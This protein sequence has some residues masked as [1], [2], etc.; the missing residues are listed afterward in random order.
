MIISISHTKLIGPWTTSLTWPVAYFHVIT[1]NP[2]PGPTLILVWTTFYTTHITYC[3]LSVWHNIAPLL[4][5]R[6]YIKELSNTHLCKMLNDPYF[7]GFA[8][9]QEIFPCKILIPSSGSVQRKFYLWSQGVTKLESI[10]WGYVYITLTC[11]TCTF[12]IF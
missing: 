1:L 12:V 2:N 5:L 11:C 4:F 6:F 10:L 9:T 7:N 3:Y 8:W